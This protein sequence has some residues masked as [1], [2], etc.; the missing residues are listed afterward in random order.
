MTELSKTELVYSQMLS[1][2]LWCYWLLE[3]NAAWNAERVRAKAPDYVSDTTNEGKPI[4]INTLE[5][6]KHE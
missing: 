3:W 1:E 2:Q 6:S 5:D 4:Y